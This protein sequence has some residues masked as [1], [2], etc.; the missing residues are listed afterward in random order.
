MDGVRKSLCECIDEHSGLHV[1]EGHHSLVAV[2]KDSD[3]WRSE[4]DRQ[5]G[6]G[7]CSEGVLGPI[8]QAEEPV[9]V[10]GAYG[11]FALP[12]DKPACYPQVPVSLSSHLHLEE[13]SV[14]HFTALVWAS[15]YSH[16][17]I[18]PLFD[19]SYI[20]NNLFAN[21][22]INCWELLACYLI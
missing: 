3:P 11:D 5:A 12:I 22:S 8:P 2:H 9:A 19:Q 16:V 6:W 10:G 17:I 18:F 15:N 4:V 13:S 1:V 21:S 20:N 7:F 14:V